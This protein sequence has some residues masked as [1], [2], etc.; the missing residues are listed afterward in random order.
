VDS[1]KQKRE[2]RARIIAQR[3][4]LAAGTRRAWSS[5]IT[6]RLE[7]L[8]EY[9]A[10]RLVAAYA[11][12]RGE[13]DT[14]ELIQHALAGGK[15]VVV[16]RVSPRR[17]RIEFF[18]VGDPRRDLAPGAWGIPEPRAH[19]AGLGGDAL[20]LVLTPGV[21]FTRRGERLGYGRGFYDRF[22]AQYGG[23]PRLVA[24]AYSIQV[25]ERLPTEAHDRRVQRVVTEQETIVIG[26]DAGNQP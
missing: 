9:R 11:S 12:Y 19:C 2:I 22:L 24:A 3:E 14:A 25:V 1:H 4:A 5:A 13:F 23:R 17:D 21:A 8:P 26:N 15:R 10:A 6:E 16:P 18:F 7:A 20:D